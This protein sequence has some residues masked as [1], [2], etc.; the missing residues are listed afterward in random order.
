MTLFVHLGCFGARCSVVE[1]AAIDS[2]ACRWIKWKKTV[3]FCGG[4]SASK[5][6]L[7]ASSFV[8]GGC[9]RWLQTSAKAA[10]VDVSQTEKLAEEKDEEE[11]PAWI[12]NMLLGCSMEVVCFKKG[13]IV[14]I[15]LQTSPRH[16]TQAS[17]C[18]C[19]YLH[20]SPWCL[21]QVKRIMTGCMWGGGKCYFP[22]RTMF[23]SCS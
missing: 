13:I 7:F 21:S 19:T 1:R 9:T 23:S 11:Q 2:Y 12:I 16:N 22:Y 8:Q 17:V 20:L 3:L 18:M 14:I 6:V 4:P 15:Q 10:W 5:S